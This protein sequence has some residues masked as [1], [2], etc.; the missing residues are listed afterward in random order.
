VR[1]SSL[2][3]AVLRRQ[4]TGLKFITE[5]ATFNAVISRWSLVIS[6]IFTTDYWL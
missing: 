5:S 4:S 1:N 3:D 6:K 2:F